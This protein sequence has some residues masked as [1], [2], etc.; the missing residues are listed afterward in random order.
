MLVVQ[1]S[2]IW[3]FVQQVLLRKELV[4]IMRVGVGGVAVGQL[5]TRTLRVF[6]WPA[7]VIMGTVGHVDVV[8]FAFLLAMAGDKIA[9][10]QHFS[11]IDSHSVKTP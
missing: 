9:K 1:L 6:V 2:K 11:F 4:V 7:M 10:L 8:Q 3:Q 5:K